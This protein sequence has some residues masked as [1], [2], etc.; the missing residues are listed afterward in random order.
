MRKSFETPSMR[1]SKFRRE[2]IL[3]ASGDI[4]A[5]QAAENG[6]R[7]QAE[8]KSVTLTEVVTLTW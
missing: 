5:S 2:S 8:A 6:I 4:T 7:E 1:I 3:T